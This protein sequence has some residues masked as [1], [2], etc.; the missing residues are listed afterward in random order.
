MIQLSILLISC[1]TKNY[2]NDLNV[3]QSTALQVTA[4]Q[5]LPFSGLKSQLKNEDTVT[6]WLTETAQWAWN[7]KT[8]MT[9]RRNRDSKFEP[10]PVPLSDCPMISICPSATLWLPYNID[11]PQCQ[12]RTV[13]WYQ[14]AP[15]PLSDSP[16][17]WT[18]PSATLWLSYDMKLPQCHSWTV[19]W[20]EPAPVT[21][22]DCPIS[23]C[24][25]A[26]LGLSHVIN[27]PQCHS[28]TVLWYQPAPVTLSNCP[29]IS[30]CPSA[31]LGLSYDINLSATLGVSYHMNL[32]QCHSRT[33]L[34]H[35]P[36]LVPLSDCPMTWTCPS[37]NLELSY[38]YS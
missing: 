36:A 6:C 23:T 20:Y 14:P 12:S 32:P 35:E 2:A 25:S 26:T 13:L 7:I 30:T 10:A 37:A 33:V 18:C 1:Y 28:R 22:S 5:G 21:L 11:L 9:D 16:M 19:L 38:D 24:S 29:M 8:I 34:W 17:I 31:T 15:A 4:D 27:L 3:K